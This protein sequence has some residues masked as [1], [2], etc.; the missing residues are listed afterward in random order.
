M[1]I[2]YFLQGLCPGNRLR[3]LNSYDS[4]CFSPSP[5]SSP[6]PSLA[7]STATLNSSICSA[8]IYENTSIISGSGSSANG[9]GSGCISASQTNITT[10]SSQSCTTVT[11]SNL[12]Q[13]QGTRRSW[14]VSPN[15]VRKK[16]NFFSSST[17]SFTGRQNI[18]TGRNCDWPNVKKDNIQTLQHNSKKVMEKVMLQVYF[19]SVMFKMRNFFISRLVCVCLYYIHKMWICAAFYLSRHHNSMCHHIFVTTHTR[20][21]V[22]CLQVFWFFFSS[23]LA[24]FSNALKF[25]LLFLVF[26]IFLVFITCLNSQWKLTAAVV[27]EKINMTFS[28]KVCCKNEKSSHKHHMQ[29]IS[30]FSLSFFCVFMISFS[31]TEIII[32]KLKKRKKEK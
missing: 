20:T 23:S 10:T 19:L 28:G 9:S 25:K 13:R 26:A 30:I 24:N 12:Q 6:C 21:T 32:S 14:H 29:D 31:A 7:A 4:G 18:L 5:A 27:M 3:I 16:L 8:D 1:F 2:F 15:K 22:T 17:F 11:T